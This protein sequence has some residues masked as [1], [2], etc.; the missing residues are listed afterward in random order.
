MKISGIKLL[1][2]DSEKRV[3]P[4]G[5]KRA[6]AYWMVEMGK[7]ITG[8]T[9]KRRFFESAGAAKEHID[10]VLE[11]R[12]EEGNETFII[13]PALRVEAFRC[14]EELDK[15][16]ATVG[17]PL[18]LSEAVRFFLKH[19][20]PAGGT[21]LF[22]DARLAFIA[23]RRA[24]NL[25]E[26]YIT[27]LDSQFDQLEK[28]FAN[29][30]VNLI[31][32]RE[33]ESWLDD[34]EQSPKTR[35]NYIVT[36]RTFFDYC[37]AQKWAAENPAAAI[38]KARVEDAPAGILS[39]TE[40]ERLLAAAADT[41]SPALA[42]IAIQ[43]FAGLRR[44]EVCA[45]EWTDVRLDVIEVSAAKA[46][47]RARRVVDI[48]PNL[49]EWLQDLRKEKEPVFKGSED[50]YNEAIREVLAH[51]NAQGAEA[52]PPHTPI[53]WKHNCLRHTCASMHLA[54]FE[55][56]AKTALQMGHSV[57]ILHRHYKG[58]ATR[59]VASNYWALRPSK[60][61]EEPIPFQK[62]ATGA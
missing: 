50:T 23:S 28:V 47:T 58:L 43:L 5:S 55:D 24:A 51:A 22:K 15:A 40:A 25:K 62:A 39:V 53:E 27:N 14:K 44:S 20:L 32:T 31:T 30:R 9:R 38:D 34:R 54:F 1:K 46:K 11:T 35:N 16:A 21:S 19:A 42:A 18:S 7:K 52:K 2:L 60:Q 56:E 17:R 36:L 57:D 49:L 29:K 33:L 3:I 45:L 8:T 26:R 12:A 4:K 10:G 61:N 6:A 59:T 48:Q 41:K 37:V 13:P